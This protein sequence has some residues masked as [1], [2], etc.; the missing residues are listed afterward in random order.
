LN[1]RKVSTLIYFDENSSDEHMESVIKIINNL[2]GVKGTVHML[3]NSH[4]ISNFAKSV[5]EFEEVK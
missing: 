1:F 2:E 3:D 5:K 4:D